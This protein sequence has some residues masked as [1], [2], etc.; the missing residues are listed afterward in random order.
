MME[1]K[2]IFMDKEKTQIFIEGKAMQ[3]QPLE[4]SFNHHIQLIQNDK[5]KFT[6]ISDSMLSICRRSHKNWK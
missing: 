1:K 4:D 5:A 2:R 3:W 6:D